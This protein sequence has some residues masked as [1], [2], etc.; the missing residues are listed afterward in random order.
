MSGYTIHSADIFLDTLGV[1]KY[2]RTQLQSMF[3]ASCPLEITPP[4]LDIASVVAF[5][6]RNIYCQF[7]ITFNQNDYGYNMLT[8][9]IIHNNTGKTGPT[10]VYRCNSRLF[11]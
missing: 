4:G 7:P 2:V 10:A 8:I 1:E 6:R 3:D 11:D 5:M 9:E